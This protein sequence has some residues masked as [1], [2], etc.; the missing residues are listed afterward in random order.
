MQ[1]QELIAGD[2]LNFLTSVPGYPASEGWAL[3]YRLVPRASGNTPLLINPVAEGSDYRTQVPAATTTGYAADQYTWFSWVEKGLETYTVDT[4]QIIIKPN[5]RTAAAGY[6]GR[7]DARKALEDAKA[8]RTS[9]ISNNGAVR[10]YKIADREREFNSVSDIIKLI[11]YLE[12]EVLKEDR[13]A[14]RADQPSRRI[15]T[16]L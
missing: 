16:R 9:W 1:V 14:G 8:A 13:L 15:Y 7:T 2:T 10:S 11:T 3:K 6:D 5:P 4:G 12:Q